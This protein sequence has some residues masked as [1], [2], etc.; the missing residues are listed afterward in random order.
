[1]KLVYSDKKTGRSAQIELSKDMEAALLNRKVGDVVEGAFAGLPGFKLKITGGSDS[2]GFPMKK[3]VTGTAKR[4]ILIQA[5][6]SGRNKGERRRS[7]VVGNTISASTAQVN[8][9]I[10]EYGD[11]SPDE[12]FPKKEAEKKEDKK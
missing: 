7:T 5:N 9:S 8:A 4:K 12:I 11:K 2:S 10:E 1:M 6:P 3:N